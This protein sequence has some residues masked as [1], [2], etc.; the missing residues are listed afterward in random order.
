MIIRLL[1]RRSHGRAAPQSENEAVKGRMIGMKKWLI[2][3]LV[4]CMPFSACAQEA[5][6][7]VTANGVVESSRVEYIMAPFS[8][9]V[10]PF[11]WESGER[12]AQGDVLFALETLKIYA[13][14]EGT[15]R[16]VFAGEGE[17]AADVMAQYGMLASIEK[18]RHF[19]IDASTSGAYNE[20]ENRYIHTG[21]MVYVEQSSD[22]DNKGTG[23]IVAAAGKDYTIELIKGDF[24]EGDKVKIYRD[25]TH[26]SK[27]CIGSGTVEYA[28]DV[29]VSGNGYV[30]R[31]AVKE[32]EKV[33]QGDLL[34]ELAAPDADCGLTSA[35]LRSPLDGALEVS[36]V[37]GM[38]VYKG[39][40]LA[41]VHDLSRLSVVASVDEMDLDCVKEG[42]SLTVV[43]DRYPGELV[44]GTVRQIGAL[45]TARQNAAYYDVTVEILTTLEVLPGMN[46]TL[47][48]PD[49]D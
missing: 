23:R 17:Q 11:D 31:C 2:C 39:Q 32:G 38:Q 7:H 36:V 24:E 18:Q 9:V 21:E 30:L 20:P 26:S 46:A 1:W 44:V 19:Q 42:D 40:V 33:Q 47:Y 15:V 22:K 28:T 5:D 49:G 10:R 14:V 16:S 45:G 48:L 41:K 13:P 37:P 27:S 6:A 12:T 34:F 43:F 29:A 3:L 4:L 8:G 35:V 25:D